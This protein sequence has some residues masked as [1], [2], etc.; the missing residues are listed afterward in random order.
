MRIYRNIDFSGELAVVASISDAHFQ[1]SLAKLRARDDMIRAFRL[2]LE[3]G[4]PVEELSAETGFSPAVIT[5][6]AGWNLTFGED[7][8]ALAGISR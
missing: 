5:Q 4:V 2:A 1:A 8:D 3:R 7:L 6:M